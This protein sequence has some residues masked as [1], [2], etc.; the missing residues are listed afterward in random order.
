MQ[1]MLKN[2]FLFIAVAACVL[3]GVIET[4]FCKL[5]SIG[6]LS[7]TNQSINLCSLLVERVLSGV[8]LNPEF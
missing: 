3:E 5:L 6:Y 8:R 7:A 4:K 1:S 2:K